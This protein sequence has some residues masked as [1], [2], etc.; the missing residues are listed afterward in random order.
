MLFMVHNPRPIGGTGIDIGDTFPDTAPKAEET[1]DLAAGI[2]FPMMHRRQRRHWNC[3][4]EY[5][6]RCCT[7]GTGS[8]WNWR[9]KYYSRCCTE[10]PGGTGIGGWNTVPDAAPKAQEVLELAAGRIDRNWSST[11][12]RWQLG[13]VTQLVCAAGV[14]VRLMCAAS[15][16]AASTFEAGVFMSVWCVYVYVWVCLFVWSFHYVSVW[17]CIRLSMCQFVCESICHG[18]FVYVFE[19]LYSAMR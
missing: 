14:R 3:R 9:L 6:S 15:V 12:R 10:G 18:Q 4:L 1:L 16:C 11:R 8:T 17:V 2:L 13:L 7:E 19:V 5:Y